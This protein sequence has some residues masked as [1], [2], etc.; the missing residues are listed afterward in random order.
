LHAFP[1][2]KPY[3][4]DP[5]SYHV[6]PGLAMLAAETT[7]EPGPAEGL[8]PASDQETLNG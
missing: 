7:L 1:I 8:F 6:T 4:P 2:G 3:P 5:S